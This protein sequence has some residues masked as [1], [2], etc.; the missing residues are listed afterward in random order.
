MTHPP[1]GPLDEVRL[2]LDPPRPNAAPRPRRRTVLSYEELRGSPRAFRAVVGMKV[3]D[4]DALAVAL[5]PRMTALSRERVARP[6][7][8]RA[9]GGGHPFELSAS[10]QI[11][12]AVVRLRHSLIYE[13]LAYLFGVSKST[14]VRTLERVVPLLVAALGARRGRSP[15][16]GHLGRPGRPSRSRPER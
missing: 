2:P 7:R 10:D 15:I 13:V 12:L 8:K 6:G 1:P 9:P 16:G 14:V 11:L 4:F 5:A 3:A